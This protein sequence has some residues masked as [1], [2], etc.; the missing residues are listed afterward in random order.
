MIGLVIVTHGHLAD[1]LL[2]AL[3]H[4]VGPQEAVRTIAVGPEDVMDDRRD[5]VIEAVTSL[6]QGKGR[7][8]LH[9]YVRRHA[10][11]SG[12]RCDRSGARRGA[13]RREPADAGQARQHAQNREPRRGCRQ[14]L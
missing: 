2:H 7:D 6:D 14:C 12:N 13:D 4:V 5:E 3:E 9:R 8:Y 11:Q 1:E 10:V